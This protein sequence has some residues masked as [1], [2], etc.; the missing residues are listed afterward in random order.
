M[1][2][3][4]FASF[5]FGP[6][7]E[8]RAQESL[9]KS[10]IKELRDSVTAFINAKDNDE[11]SAQEKEIKRIETA[12]ETL[13][14]I[15]RLGL[16]EISALKDRLNEL[17]IE[18]LVITD[19]TFDAS[20]VYDSLARLLEYYEAYHNDTLKKVER[21]KNYD[22]AKNI[23]KEIK[24]WR[25]SIYAPGIQKIL[26]LDLVLRNK[27]ILGI[28]DARFEKILSDLRKLKNSKLLT[29]AE[30]EALLNAA[31]ANLK[32]AEAL[33]DEATRLILRALKENTLNPPDKNL[34]ENEV[35][36]SSHKRISNLVDQ[37]IIKIKDA[38]KKFIEINTKVK[39]ILELE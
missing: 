29:F 28:A 22:E 37:S 8:A 25:E 10:A 14:K 26:S 2:A 33:D 27:A 4:F 36:I 35:A 7:H 11:I 39:K 5:I 12:K 13:K 19:Y 30:L 1:L 32:T 17:E 20:E 38:Y 21:L 23:A 34:D 15:L 18:K 31:T 16:V 24:K 9:I 3:L 6:H